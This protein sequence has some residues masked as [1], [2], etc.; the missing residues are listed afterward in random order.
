MALGG[1]RDA[2]AVQMAETLHL[3]LPPD[4][5]HPA[6]AE[7]A[8][9]LHTDATPGYT[10]QV[11][12]RLWG[13][14]GYGFLPAYL[15]L[16]RQHYGAELAEVDFENALEE[17]RTRINAWV[18]R[19]TE[20][21]IQ[22]LVA[23]GMLHRLTR[24]VLTN[25]IYFKGAWTHP[26]HEQGTRATPFYRAS[27]TPVDVPMMCQTDSFLYAHLKTRRDGALQLLAMPYGAE[28]DLSMII[29]LPDARDGLS[30]LEA[31]L[32]P[33]TL[34]AWIAGLHR[35]KVQVLLPR[36]TMTAT[37]D[38]TKT[39]RHMGMVLPFSPDEEAGFAGMSDHE[40]LFISSVIHKAFVDVHEAGTE[41]AAATFTGMVGAAANYKPPPVFRAD[42]PFIFLIRDNRTGSLLFL[43]RVTD[44]TG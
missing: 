17:A 7:L 29:L 4:I 1:A 11:A 22:H 26:F 3:S 6:F 10:I 19:Q 18:A 2:T 28:E 24:L 34:H 16:T 27:A 40:N 36:F 38:L 42:H 33:G 41:A 5:L 20:D 23:P 32:Q 31:R 21:K 35:Q 30:D 44:P 37:F 14:Q 43:G 9:L 25:A 39:L 8:T 15:T 12:N 13:Q